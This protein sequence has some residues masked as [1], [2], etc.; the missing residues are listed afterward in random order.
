MTGF[1]SKFP[2]GDIDGMADLFGSVVG[3]AR[4]NR[5]EMCPTEFA[6]EGRVSVVGF[7]GMIEYVNENPANLFRF[8][9]DK[10]LDLDGIDPRFEH[11]ILGG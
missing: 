2:K 5:I 9:W 11:D 4:D 6:A 10:E 8:L 1:G 3:F 7:E